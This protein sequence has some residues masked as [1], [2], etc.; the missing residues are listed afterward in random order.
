MVE[1]NKSKVLTEYLSE[2]EALADD[3]FKTKI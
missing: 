3:L 1:L 2:R